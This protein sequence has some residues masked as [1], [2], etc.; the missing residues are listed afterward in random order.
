ME[1]NKLW[2]LHAASVYLE[3]YLLKQHVRHHRL[4]PQTWQM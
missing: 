2:T 3:V 1:D 4:S